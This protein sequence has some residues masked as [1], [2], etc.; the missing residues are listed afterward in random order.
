MISTPALIT[1]IKWWAGHVARIEDRTVSC[2]DLV[3]KPEG[4]GPLA[5]PRCRWE[6]NI[7]T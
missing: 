7:K 4:K 5:R 3:W 1:G 2:S 6:G